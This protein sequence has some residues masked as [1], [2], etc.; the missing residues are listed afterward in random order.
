[1]SIRLPLVI[2]P[3]I[4]TAIVQSRM[5]F[6]GFLFDD[7][8]HLYTV[9]NLPFMEAIGVPM[10]GHL[11]HSFTTVVWAL[12]S[13]FGL[14]P[15]VF[16]LIGFLAHLAAVYLL[17]QIVSELTGR[18]ALAAFGAT[19]WGISP[20]VAGALGWISVHGQV[21]ATAAVL[22]V[23]LDIVRC[24]QSARPLPNSLLARHVILMLIAVTSFGV[25]LTSA[26]VLPLLIMLWNPLPAERNRLLAVY[27]GVALAAVVLYVITMKLQ[28]DTQDNL[29]DKFNLVKQ[30]LRNIPIISGAFADL[31]AIGS[32]ALVLGPLL[33]G[34]LS[35]VPIKSLP[36]VAG[37]FAVFVSLPLLLWG[38]RVS[39]PGE[40][41]RILA[42]LL[43]PCAVYGLIAVA[44]SDGFL[45]VH[46]EAPRYHYFSPAI[47]AIVYCLLVSKL[48]DRLPARTPGYG[49]SVPYFIWLALA[50]VPF[51]MGTAS[52]NSKEARLTR[53][54]N[55]LI[56]STRV[57]ETAL[58]NAVGEGDIY[59]R[60][61]PFSVFVWG[62]TPE[63]FPG[64]AGL[65]VISYP[66][67][68]VDGRRVFFLEDSKELVEMAGGQHGSRISELLVYK[69]KGEK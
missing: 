35:L 9:S 33:V 62:Y 66:D 45:V 19:L 59:I 60:N 37:M 21:F 36:F 22:W 44:R 29:D 63:F 49:R 48:L 39:G 28:G 43:L 47:F 13:L 64:L 10:G 52:V 68:T 41:R 46:S 38:L 69:P 42:L 25:G 24:S 18:A 32:S 34:K 7:F 58:E 67:N 31:V 55:Q 3:L 54:K 26:V 16:L 14:N 17:F 50:I 61:R 2:W 8:V 1:M 23:L 6:N 65:F 51:A 56:Q 4:A 5:L 30:S 12:K 20:F 27:G 57:L 53:Q 15:F 11:L 40:R